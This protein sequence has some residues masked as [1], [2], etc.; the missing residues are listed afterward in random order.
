[1]Q[2]WIYA[3]V[4]VLIGASCNNKKSDSQL[5]E[6]LYNEVIDI[7][8]EVMPKMSELKNLSMQLTTTAD[9]IL[10]ADS[11]QVATVEQLKELALKLELANESMMEWMRN[12]QPPSDNLPHDSVMNYLSQQKE[13]IIEVKEG[14]LTARAKA[15]N[16]LEMP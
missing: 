7:H 8:D 4:V 16:R 9:S 11:T 15:R 6:S 12:F 10:T 14:M 5:K 1:M 3:L 13:M 2:K